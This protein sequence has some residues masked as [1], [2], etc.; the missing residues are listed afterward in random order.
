MKAVVSLTSLKSKFLIPTTI[1]LV[2]SFLGLALSIIGTQ[3][4][5]LL[6]MGEQVNQSLQTSNHEIQ[7]AFKRMDA[8][9]VATLNR[10]RET[11]TRQLSAS[12]EATLSAERQ[13]INDKWLEALQSNADSTAELLAQV[14]PP[15]IL[16]FD[17][18]S[19]IAYVKAATSNPDTVFAFYLKPD[20]KPLTRYIDRKNPKI[21]AYIKKGNR[22]KKHQQVISGAANDNSVI[23]VENQLHLKAKSWE[24]CCFVSAKWLL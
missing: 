14:A 5:L 10:M 15:A 17:F 7:N 6:E 16:S 20:G 8:E 19:L 12:T 11:T 4:G 21:A 24:R 9:V 2:I 22:S 18:T 23:L 1:L 3:K 13:R